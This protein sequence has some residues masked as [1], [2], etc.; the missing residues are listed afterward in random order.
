[1]SNTIRR[2]IPSR[3]YR[4]Y[5][6]L[7]IIHHENGMWMSRWTRYMAGFIWLESAEDKSTY[8]QYAEAKIRQYHMDYRPK[9][10]CPGFCHRVDTLRQKRQHKAA[11]F[12]AMRS[13]DFEVV[14]EPYVNEATRMWDWY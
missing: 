10:K 1:M 4:K 14:L 6:S 8:D 11:L 12:Q 3:N 2:G 5:I 13:G 9:S 7:G